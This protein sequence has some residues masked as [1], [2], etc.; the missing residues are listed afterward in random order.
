MN[1]PNLIA[2]AKASG[3]QIA[4]TMANRRKIAFCISTLT[5]NEAVA[6]LLRSG[7]LTFKECGKIVGHTGEPMRMMHAKA[8]AKLARRL[9][10]FTFD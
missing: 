4:D 5:V 7:G 2:I 8:Q 1:T 3:H 9:S 6:L 10:V